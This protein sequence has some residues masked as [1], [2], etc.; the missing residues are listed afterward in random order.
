MNKNEKEK[1]DITR[2][3]R[4]NLVRLLANSGFR[5]ASA[6]LLEKDIS[7]GA[8]VNDDGTINLF[9]FAAWLYVAGYNNGGVNG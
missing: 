1:I 7:D 2:L 6:E 5:D 9:D 4:E 8:P 3:S